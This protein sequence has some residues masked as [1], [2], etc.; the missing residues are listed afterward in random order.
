MVPAEALCSDKIRWSAPLQDI[1]QEQS[2][3]RASCPRQVR[4]KLFS[5]LGPPEYSENLR[6]LRRLWKD[7]HRLRACQRPLLA[8]LHDWKSELDRGYGFV[9]RCSGLFYHAL[10]AQEEYRHTKSEPLHFGL[11]SHCRLKWSR[12]HSIEARGLTVCPVV[13]VGRK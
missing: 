11:R 3:A 13:G 4:N 7:L 9:N 2:H 12:R 10:S 5:S 8:Q 6:N 1:P